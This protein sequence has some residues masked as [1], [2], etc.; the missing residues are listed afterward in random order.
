MPLLTACL[1]MLPRLSAEESQAAVVRTAVGT[2]SFPPET[3]AAIRK[4]WARQAAGP[5]K[6]KV[7]VPTAR[8]MAA[9]GI[10][11]IR[12]PRG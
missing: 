6:P 11:A 9:I 4:E 2:G 8:E 1:T 7:V 5:A 3:S 12:V 10:K